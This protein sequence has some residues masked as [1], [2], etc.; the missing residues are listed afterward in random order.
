MDKE[1]AT[2]VLQKELEK[3]RSRR[4]AELFDLIDSPKAYE[5]SV[6]SGN[7][8]QIEIQ[9][10]WDDPREPGGDLRVIASID[11]GGLL[12]ALVPLSMDFIVSPFDSGS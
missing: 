1:E 8:Y 12:S 11:D 7:T 5:I 2:E 9:A 4:Y 10:F 6:S 3:L